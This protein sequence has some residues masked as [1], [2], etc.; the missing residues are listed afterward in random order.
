MQKLDKF[1]L[2]SLPL[3]HYRTKALLDLL[4]ERLR[5]FEEYLSENSKGSLILRISPKRFGN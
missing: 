2:N 1:F 5:Q 4:E 3:W